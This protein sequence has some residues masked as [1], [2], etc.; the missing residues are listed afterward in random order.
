ME[1][2]TILTNDIEQLQDAI[3]EAIEY[4]GQVTD[5]RYDHPIVALLQEALDLLDSI[6]L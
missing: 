2:K 3:S 4:V 6:S 5:E 1:P